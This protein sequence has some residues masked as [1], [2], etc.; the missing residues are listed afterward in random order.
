MEVASQVIQ[1]QSSGAERDE[2][3]GDEII[4]KEKKK[5]EVGKL[6]DG[7]QGLR[8]QVRGG[9]L[10]QAR[11]D[12]INTK[13]GFDSVL[14]VGRGV[15]RLSSKAVFLSPRACASLSQKKEEICHDRVY[16]ASSDVWVDTINRITHDAT[17]TL[18]DHHLVLVDFSKERRKHSR[19]STYLKAALEWFKEVHSRERILRKW[20]ETAVEEDTALIRWSR[21]RYGVREVLKEMDRYDIDYGKKKCNDHRS[22]ELYK[23]RSRLLQISKWGQ[24]L[25]EKLVERQKEISELEKKQEVYWRRYSQIKWLKGGDM[26][27]K[28]S[29][30]NSKRE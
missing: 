13:W 26:P 16:F 27:C 6:Q 10:E 28:Y 5:R 20:K 23:L 4:S 30:C 21:N 3:A 14:S 18:S 15:R 7:A 1:S 24:P 19:R 8:Q 2:E 22:E 12:R 17:S 29:N 25:T 9:K 11:L